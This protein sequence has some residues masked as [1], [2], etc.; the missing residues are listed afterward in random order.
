M[1]KFDDTNLHDV[2]QFI[3]AGG[4][5]DMADSGQIPAAAVKSEVV[6]EAIEEVFQEVPVEDLPKVEFNGLDIANPLELLI[7]LD[8]DIASGKVKLHK[9]Q[10]KIQMDF[11]TGGESDQ[12]PLQQVVRA[13]NGSGK[14]K[15]VIAPCVVWLCMRYKMARGVITS[16]SGQQLDS[17]TGTY[18]DMLCESANRKFNELFG[19]PVWKLNYRYYECLA[20]GS[21]LALFATDE[22]RKA[23]GYHPLVSGG[24]MVIA[25]SE[26]KSV[27]DDINIA[28]N[29]CTG[30]TH[31]LHV[32]TPGHPM[33]HFFDYCSP[34]VSVRREDITSVKDVDATTW[35]QYHVT[36][37][38][39]SHLSRAYIEQMKRDLPGGETGVAF[40]SQVL[41]EFGS[42]DQMVVIPSN[43]V[44]QAMNGCKYGWKQKA[45]NDAGLD[46][47]DGGD[48]TVLTIRNGNRLLHVIAFKFDNTQD[49]IR[50]L[51]DNFRKY[52]LN[53][54]N[55]RI[56]ADC[57]GLGKP[58]LDQL[59]A[60]G[61]TNIHYIDN[62]NTPHEPRT[63]KNRGAELW[64]RF[65]KLL[66]LGELWLFSDDKLRQQLSTRFYTI[67]PD[68]KHQL[69]SKIQ[70]R[71][72]GHPS[73]D[74]A[75]AVVLCFWDY[76][77]QS[78]AV[79]VSKPFEPPV[80]EEKPVGAL[81]LKEYAKRDL[82]TRY[83]L[84]PSRNFDFRA[85]NDLIAEH[86]RIIK[87]I[88]SN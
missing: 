2:E 22:P 37:Y 8:E 71:G 88:E 45:H 5:A 39:C 57:G 27:P 24:K 4:L 84:K 75:D 50:F 19:G 69:E 21:P 44:W 23:E 3:N 76:E 31:R 68:N 47:S 28:L 67:T 58:I 42:A 40:R 54:P 70:A 73:P 83:T 85:I 48:E 86:N 29:K 59:K 43:Y 49:T 72:K 61:W 15:Y 16:S 46:L 10:V 34:G 63:Y 32:S 38:D 25:V 9:W 87:S 1:S 6:K 74:R 78:A 20:T 14:D 55:S 62:R 80:V 17:Q 36:A 18:I 77:G 26:D 65:R 33:G 82:D 60:M 35:I 79:K 81:S 56:N 11:A 41:A 30:Y 53:N 12:H 51:D 64:F 13:C 52:G 7:L 66:E